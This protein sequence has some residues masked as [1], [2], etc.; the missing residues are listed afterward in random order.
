[1]NF[2]HDSLLS[3]L[4]GCHPPAACQVFC[5][6]LRQGGEAPGLIVAALLKSSAARA[7]L[8]GTRPLPHLFRANYS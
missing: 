8:R 6:R 4:F 7:A 5:A 2:Q 1:D 3:F